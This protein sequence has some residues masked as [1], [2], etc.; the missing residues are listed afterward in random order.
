MQESELVPAKGSFAPTG[1]SERENASVAVPV[2][3]LG[4]RIVEVL[5]SNDERGKEDSVTSAVHALCHLW[6]ARLE[7]VQ[8]DQGAEQGRHLDV[9]LLD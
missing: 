8:V 9:G 5:G 7:P 6:Q 1:L 4:T 3:V 2:L